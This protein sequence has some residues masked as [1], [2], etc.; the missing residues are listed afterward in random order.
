MKS[1]IRKAVSGTCATAERSNMQITPSIT[2]SRAVRK[3]LIR[4]AM[5][6][7]FYEGVNLSLA[8]CDDCGH[9]ELEMGMSVPGVAA[10]GT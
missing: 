3:T 4:R 6:K 10:A 9:Q 1:R 7:G 5:D 8:Y 2:I